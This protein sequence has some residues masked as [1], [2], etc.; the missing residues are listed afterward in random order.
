M[1]IAIQLGYETTNMGDEIGAWVPKKHV[2]ISPLAQPRVKK[3]LDKQNPQI[4]PRKRGEGL[5][6]LVP[7]EE[8]DEVPDETL[9]QLKALEQPKSPK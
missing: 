6:Y 4:E 7:L 2:L 8:I 5:F 3:W 1:A 9:E